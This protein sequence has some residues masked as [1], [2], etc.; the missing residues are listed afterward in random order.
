MK[1]T[2]ERYRRFR[3]IL[4]LALVLALGAAPAGCGRSSRGGNGGEDGGSGGDDGALDALT[5]EQ[6]VGQLFLVGIEG[7][8]VT[9]EIERLFREVHPGGVVLFSR[10]IVDEGR[11]KRLISDLQELSHADSGLPLLV[12]VDQEGGEVSRLGWLEDRVPQAQVADPE[13]AYR[14]ALA[15]ARG[16]AE[17][18]INLNLAPVL[19][20]GVRGDFLTRH[21]RTFS[22]G[23]EEV[24]EMGKSAISG[25]RDGGILSC[26]KH[27]PGYGGIDYDPENERLAVVPS[28]PE[29]SQ[30]QAAAAADPE[31]V[32]TANVIYRELDPEV[33][34]TLSPS[35]I[36]FLR[37][38]VAGEYLVV[39]DDLAS[40]VLKEAYGLGSTV[41]HACK[42]GV[43]VLLISG[44]EKGDV[45]TAYTALLEAARS[46]EITEEE[47][48]AHVAGI[49]RLKQ[50]LRPQH[51]GQSGGSCPRST[52]GVDLR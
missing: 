26:A 29:F 23:P 32:M 18:G 31:F 13:Q 46:G 12:A 22:G 21:R 43:Q 44:Y 17:V 50:R 8:E 45:E 20:L 14:M 19:D 3:G 24:G 52:A 28:L 37:E 33:P 30:F 6:K 42:A 51:G 10:N 4:V 38:K 47:L 39:S 1:T 48:D 5:L 25:Q 49:L 2:H 16:L 27:F 36:A 9:P 41:V 15:R 7:T 34:F 40:K 35:C 11:L